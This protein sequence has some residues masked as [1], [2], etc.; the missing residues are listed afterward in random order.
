MNRKNLTFELGHNRFSHYTLGEFHEN[1]GIRG[2]I[3][4]KPVYWSD[5]RRK[6]IK[7][8]VDWEERGGV[9]PVKDQGSCGSCWSFSTTGLLEGAYFIKYGKL[10]SFSEQMLVSCDNLDYGCDGGSVENALRWI[11]NN[12]GI[13]LEEDYPYDPK[14]GHFPCCKKCETVVRGTGNII[15]KRIFPLEYQLEKAVIEQPIAVGI[16][17]STREFQ[18]YQGGVF[19]G[20]CGSNIDHGVLVVGF[21][22]GD[23]GI[24]FWKV[25]NSWGTDWGMNGYILIEKNYTIPGGK[26][27]IH[28]DAYGAKL[29]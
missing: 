27:G 12:K 8:Y 3:S 19:T 22:S 9:T 29:Y 6:Y 21:G 1:L 4:V 11:K 20:D 15:V 7:D 24:N 5:L 13:C 28:K 18:F 14:Y 23:D 17:A 26:C 25:K 2:V 16:D 10:L